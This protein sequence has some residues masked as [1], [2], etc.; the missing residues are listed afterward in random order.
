MQF[1][2]YSKEQEEDLPILIQEW[3]SEP[4][5]I[6]NYVDP[7]NKVIE[8][9]PDFFSLLLNLIKNAFQNFTTDKDE[10]VYFRGN[11]EKVSNNVLQN[12]IKL[13]IQKIETSEDKTI[14]TTLDNKQFENTVLQDL[15]KQLRN[16]LI[17][18]E[19]IHMEPKEAYCKLFN[20]LD[21]CEINCVWNPTTREVTC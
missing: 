11:G 10:T 7:I 20:N 21:G 3:C 4:L 16:D 17:L 14:Y 9:R 15:I 1:S 8:T 18:V 5:Q 13:A 12:L 2:V 19:D 6:F